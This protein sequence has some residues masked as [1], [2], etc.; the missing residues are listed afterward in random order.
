MQDYSISIYFHSNAL[1]IQF[2]SPSQCIFNVCFHFG[3]A[4]AD[5]SGS[6]Q[7]ISSLGAQQRGPGEL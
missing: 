7:Q 1:R 2:G 6:D 4:S 5:C 3:S